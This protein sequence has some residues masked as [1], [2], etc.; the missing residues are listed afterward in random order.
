MLAV[1]RQGELRRIP[2]IMLPYFKEYQS[3][4]WKIL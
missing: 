1:F 3:R 4:T 2:V